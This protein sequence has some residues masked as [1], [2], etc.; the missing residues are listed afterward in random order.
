MITA[1]NEVKTAQNKTNRE[2]E[3]GNTKRAFQGI[4]TSR[5]RE[6]LL[7]YHT[8][9]LQT[10]PKKTTALTYMYVVQQKCLGSY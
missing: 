1:S 2:V 8:I 9:G 3:D 7:I 5:P 4:K 6:E 10:I